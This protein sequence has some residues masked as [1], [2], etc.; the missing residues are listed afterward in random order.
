[1]IRRRFLATAATTAAAT[2]LAPALVRAASVDFQAK[3]VTVGNS[4][5]D[6]SVEMVFHMARTWGLGRSATLS[7][8][9]IPGAPMQWNWDHA[10]GAGV[11]ARAV[12]EAG[13]QD[14][15]MGVEAVPFR[16][17]QAPDQSRSIEAWRRWHQVAAAGGV[18]R[19]LVFEAWHDLRSG[20]QGYVPVDRGDPDAGIPWRERL[21]FARPHW[22]GIAAHV[23]AGGGR[24]P[25][26][27]VVPGGPLFAAIYDDIAA[28]RAPARLRRIR[29]LF[30]DDIHPTIYGRYAMACVMFA[31]IYRRSPEGAPGQTANI[32]GGAF[33]TVDLE[34]A[35]Y[36]QTRAWEVARRDPLTGI[37]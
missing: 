24:G 25:E 9:T 35:R 29:D 37:A 28:G 33:E 27:H 18:R 21:D 22:A 5:I 8:Q 3:L 17:L 26:A 13:G 19:F 31:C 4:L 6:Q 32:W 16:F 23:N 34:T 2:A 12:L 30:V 14:V 1:M 7:H 20:E 36:F 15:W 11:N 10:S